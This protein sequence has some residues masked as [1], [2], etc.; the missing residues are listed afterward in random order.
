MRATSFGYVLGMFRRARALTPGPGAVT[1]RTTT[2]TTMAAAQ[3]ARPARKWSTD[4]PVEVSFRLSGMVL[5]PF[6]WARLRARRSALFLYTYAE[7]G[8]SDVLKRTGS[9]DK[10]Q[11]LEIMS[12]SATVTVARW[13]LLRAR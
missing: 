11:P 4:T 1:Y 5:V 9:G 13:R 6:W 10:V 7:G 12:F 3:T 2:K 8:L